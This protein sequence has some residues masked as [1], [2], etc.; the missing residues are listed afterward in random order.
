MF[1]LSLYIPNLFTHA[2]TYK[3]TTMP[4]IEHY[5]KLSKVAEVGLK[6]SLAFLLSNTSNT[7]DR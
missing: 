2:V 5:E 1:Y 6:F 4:V 7:S 3:E